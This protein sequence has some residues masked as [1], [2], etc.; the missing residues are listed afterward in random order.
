MIDA[1]INVAL[2]SHPKTKKL[3]K[4]LGT[5]AAWRLVCLFLWVSQNKPD[6]DLTGMLSED[7]E[8]AVDWDGEDGAF[9]KA[10]VDFAFVDGD[11][12]IGYCIHDWEEHNPWAAGSEA[13]SEKAR[14]AAIC[15]QHGR[16]K[17]AELMPEYAARLL[18]TAI[19]TQ[20]E[21]LESA[22]GTLLAESSSAPSPSPSPSPSPKER[23]SKDC[24]ADES[25][26]TPKAKKATSFPA[27]FAPNETCLKLAESLGVDPGAEVPKFRDHHLMKGTLGKD[28]QAGFRTWLNNAVQ[29][30]S[31]AKAST[32]AT[33]E[34]KPIRDPMI[35]GFD[36]ANG[37]PLPDGWTLPPTGETR[38]M[39]GIGWVLSPSKP[40]LPC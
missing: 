24:V 26:A 9:T 12:E 19:S 37:D 8:L 11:E 15:K 32:P 10:L 20:P 16:S 5:N 38:Y 36:V 6:G 4:R 1:R 23:K 25:S 17:A 14:W 40:R 7:I 13:R 3:I 28:W 39:P 31:G 33:A 18:K 29:F 30:G 2:P 22:S 35:F 21:V 27:D 34:G